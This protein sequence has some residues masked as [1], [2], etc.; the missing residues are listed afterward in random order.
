MANLQVRDIDNKLYDSLKKRAKRQRRSLS[1]EV[2]HIIEDY[3]SRPNIDSQ[4][5]SELFLQ[6]TGSWEGKESADEILD[7][8]RKGRTESRRFK[9]NNGIFN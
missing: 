1:Q 4:K 9:K 7:A 6:L 5:Q 3:L 2:I 8:I